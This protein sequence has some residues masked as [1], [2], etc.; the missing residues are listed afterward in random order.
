[1]EETLDP[2]GFPIEMNR[3]VVF[4]EGDWEQPHTELSITVP[5]QELG[6]QGEGYYNVPSIYGGQIYDP[7]TQFETIRENVQKQA[8]QGFRFPNF[9]SVEEAETAAQAR[10]QYFNQVKGDMLQKA[11]EERRN[12]LLM[13]L[14][15]K[16]GVELP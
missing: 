9:P 1:M 13:Q 15:E 8:A 14:L 4:E 3:P 11:M 10:S 2:H 7:Q 5:A 6:F 12:Q 16:A